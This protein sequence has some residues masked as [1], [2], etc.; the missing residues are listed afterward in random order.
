MEMLWY[1]VTK[2]RI[3]TRQQSRSTVTKCWNLYLDIPV[4]C[5]S[6]HGFKCTYS[7]FVQ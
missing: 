5:I 7:I 3:V 2:F 1:I 4:K 6:G